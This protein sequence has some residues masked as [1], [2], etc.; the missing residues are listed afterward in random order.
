MSFGADIVIHSATK[1]I[2]GHGTTVGGVIVDSG[3][4][5][6]T[7]SGSRF[8]QLTQKSDGPMPFSFAENFG[9]VAFAMALR[10]EVVMEVG[11]V[12]NPFAAQQILLGVETLSL[13]CDRIAANALRIAQYLAGHG[14]TKWI[15]YPGE[16][17]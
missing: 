3:R 12:M 11:S 16:E 10:I 2:G 7:K 17:N 14:R 15:S 6:W 13:R 9:P 5:D 4:F 1:W 8:P